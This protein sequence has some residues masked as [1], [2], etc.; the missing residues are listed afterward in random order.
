M[1]QTVK[2]DFVVSHAYILDN[3]SPFFR[4]KNHSYNLNV[5]IDIIPVVYVFDI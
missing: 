1:P 2:P 4:K 3:D 5:I